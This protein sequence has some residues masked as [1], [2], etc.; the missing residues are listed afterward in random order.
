MNEKIVP[1]TNAAQQMVKIAIPALTIFS[2]FSKG[3]WCFW[4][5]ADPAAVKATPPTTKMW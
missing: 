2:A 3:C 4:S 5:F 1:G